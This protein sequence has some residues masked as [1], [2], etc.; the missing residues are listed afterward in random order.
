MKHTTLL[1][2][3]ALLC[4]SC[5]TADRQ[6]RQ[7]AMHYLTAMGNYTFEEAYP[8]ADS[9]T[10]HTTIYYFDKIM[11]P[12]VDTNYIN[13]N[14]PAEIKIKGIVHESDTVATVRYHKHTPITEQ[15]GELKMVLENDRWVAHVVIVVPDIVKMGSQQQSD[16]T[17]FR[18]KFQG[19]LREVP[20]DSLK[21]AP[22]NRHGAPQQ[23]NP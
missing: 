22:R 18:P 4:A 16:S 11:M 14:R 3:T 7:S 10:Q 15:D 12:M 9:A 23:K 19:T 8:Y 1:I 2:A 13:S 21:I 20:K 6:I 17:I 5:H